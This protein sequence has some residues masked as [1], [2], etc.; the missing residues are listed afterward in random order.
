MTERH[1]LVEVD[2]ID[3]EN[4]AGWWELEKKTHKEIKPLKAF[5]I[6]VSKDREW[7]SIAF[8]RNPNGKDW[9][10]RFSI[11]MAVVKKVTI[12]GTR[13]LT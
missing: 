10:G 9:L 11:P 13:V 8:A 4:A 5:G 6:L 2:F 3:L 1:K 12:I 7:I